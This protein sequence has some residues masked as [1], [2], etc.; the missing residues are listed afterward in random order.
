LRLVPKRRLYSEVV[1]ATLSGSAPFFVKSK[2]PVKKGWVRYV[3][4]ASIVDHDNTNKSFG[5]GKIQGSLFVP[6]EGEYQ[7]KIDIGTFTRNTHH[8]IADEYP[9]WY[10]INSSA[11]DKLDAYFEGY[12]VELEE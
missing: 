4:S 6:M 12:E 2:Q 8:F 5:F 3:V 7:A 1:N 9:V 11:A 10:C